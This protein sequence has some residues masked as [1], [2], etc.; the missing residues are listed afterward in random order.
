MYR[1]KVKLKHWQDTKT[2]EMAIL[3]AVLVSTPILDDAV[4]EN[5]TVFS[6]ELICLVLHFI[7]NH[8][9]NEQSS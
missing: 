5:A 3:I 8:V 7:A 1:K 4:A 6:S 9:R 2:F